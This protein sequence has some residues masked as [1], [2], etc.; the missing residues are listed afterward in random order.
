MPRFTYTDSPHWANPA[1][2][3]WQVW[4]NGQRVSVGQ[5]V[6]LAN[7]LQNELNQIKQEKNERCP[8][9]HPKPYPAVP[10]PSYS[11]PSGCTTT[12]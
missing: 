6:Q 1:L 3:D 2:I 9:T 11:P 7:Q 5:L 10:C 8:T 4:D 12:T